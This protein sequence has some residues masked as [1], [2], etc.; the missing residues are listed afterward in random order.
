MK[1]IYS[2][3]QFILEHS[4]RNES[5]PEGKNAADLTRLQPQELL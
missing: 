5:D 2:L 3:K 1:E 4:V